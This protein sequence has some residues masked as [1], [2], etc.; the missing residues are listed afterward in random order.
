MA[1]VV[2]FL[3]MFLFYQ[4]LQ[5]V[6]MAVAFISRMDLQCSRILKFQITLVLIMVEVEPLLRTY[7]VFTNVLISNN[8]S[9]AGGGLL[10]GYSADASLINV[11]IVNNSA[12]QGGSSFHSR[13]DANISLINSIIWSNGVSEIVSETGGSVSD[14]QPLKMVNMAQVILTPILFF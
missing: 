1:E 8:S 11:T 12:S 4:M 14:I 6:I 7:P 5:Q 9:E 13:A 2:Q 10:C 3:K